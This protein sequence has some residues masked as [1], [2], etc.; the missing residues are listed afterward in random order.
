MIKY[1]K[2]ITLISLI[3]PIVVII[4][5]IVDIIKKVNLRGINGTYECAISIHKPCSLF[6]YVFKGDD[7]ILG[8]IALVIT[9]LPSFIAVSYIFLLIKLYKD[10]R[11]KLFWVLIVVG[12]ILLSACYFAF[13]Y[14]Q[15]I[16]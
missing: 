4:L 2:K 9:F 1:M 14:L 3:A 6:D 15:L 8:Y 7:A 5:R 16:S 10:N 13:N 11:R 12:I